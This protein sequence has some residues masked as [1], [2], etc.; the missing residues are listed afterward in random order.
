M[1]FIIF[2]DQN[3]DSFYPISLTRP[4]W[5]ILA[6]TYSFRQR[7]EKF[8]RKNF[9]VKSDLYFFSRDF[10]VPYYQERYPQLKI[11]DY[12]IFKENNQ[13]EEFLFINATSFPEKFFSNLTSGTILTKK[14][15]PLIA[16]IRLKDLNP[17]LKSIS[18]IILTAKSRQQK[19]RHNITKIDYLYELISRNK[20]IIAQDFSTFTK[21]NKSNS[22]INFQIIGPKKNLHLE[23]KVEIAPQVVFDLTS[24]PIIIKKGTKIAP[25]TFIEG[26]VFI[27]ENCL[28]LGP[29]IKGGTSIGPNCRLGGEIEQSI[30][31]GFS[32]KYHDGF[33]GNSFVG[34]WVNLGALTTNS[35]LRNDY[36]P[37]KLSLPNKI[38]ETKTHKLGCFIGDFTKTS[39][40]TLINTGTIIGPG[41]MLAN[42]GM[43]TPYHL[44][45]FS[46]YRN[47]E[48]KKIV[49]FKKFEKTA[50][51]MT[52]RREVLFSSKYKALLKYLFKLK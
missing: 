42:P 50:F 5:E 2:E 28:L 33:I 36:G 15:I 27:A 7:L 1:K 21:K 40:G 35:D 32:N 39:I 34:E 46:E 45:P 37:V 48:L 23:D 4:V 19:A 17:K 20:E 24:G 18:K 44:P 47:L 41:G 14:N 52:S 10:L 3:F 13:D 51:L 30:F 16:R 12:S 49:D 6:G 8:I 22:T 26:P 38:I 11:N 9:K 25:F 29:K 43:L 31:Q